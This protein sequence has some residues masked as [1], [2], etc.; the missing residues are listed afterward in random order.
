MSKWYDVSNEDKRIAYEQVAHQVNLPAYAIEKDWW[1][2]QTLAILF[3]MEVGQHMVFKGGTSLSKAW[4][5]IESLRRYRPG[6]NFDILV[7]FCYP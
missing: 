7:Y 4:G 3:E 1:M 2:I 5:L 6:T